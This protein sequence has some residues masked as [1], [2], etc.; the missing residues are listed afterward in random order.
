MS[1]TKAQPKGLYW[2]F[3]TETWERFS[4][5]AMRALLVLYMTAVIEQGGLGWSNEYALK[6]YG[7]Y[8]GFAYITPVLGGYM[9]D[10]FLGQRRSVLL[11]GLLMAAGHALMAVNDLTAFY[12]ALFL[13]SLGNGFFKPNVTSI[14]GGLYEPNDSRRDAGYA[15]FYMGI[16]LGGAFAGFVSGKLQQVYGFDAGFMA[17]AVAMVLGLIVFWWAQKSHYLGDVGSDAHIQQKKKEKQPLTAVEIDR[18]GV[19]FALTLAVFFFVIAFEQAGGLLNL[20]ANKWTDRNFLGVEIPAAYFQSLNPI[21]VVLMSPFVSM[22]WTRLGS[23]NPFMSTKVAIGLLLTA[24]GFVLLWAVTPCDVV[25]TECG[26]HSVWL[27][28][29]N[30]LVT[31][32][33]ICILP[34]VWSAVSKLAPRQYAS[35]LMA[36]ALF[37]IGAGGWVAGIVGSMVDDMGPA[38]IFSSIAI[39]CVVMA[40]LMV[41]VTPMLRQRTHGVE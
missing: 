19:I 32:G 38:S 24:A 29:F 7:Y 39:I 21:F 20:F 9:A 25:D 14:L 13:I 22:L 4:F 37:A 31:A 12:S 5:Y 41:A 6:I 8:L 2:L 15:I 23:K 40:A 3:M 16:N 30:A 27:V 35:S 17:A 18:I 33:E 28:P 36:L 34:V 26:C 11:G 1:P 10:A